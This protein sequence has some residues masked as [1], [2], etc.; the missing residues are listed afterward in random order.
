MQN[1]NLNVLQSLQTNY[2]NYPNF[3][4]F[5]TYSG[6]QLWP[7]E[8]YFTNIYTVQISEDVNKD[9]NENIKN[10]YLGDKI[11]FYDNEQQNKDSI[12]NILDSINEKSILYLNK[13]CYHGIPKYTNNCDKLSEVL[14]CIISKHKSEAIIIIDEM[15]NNTSDHDETLTMEN[16]FSICENRMYKY[17][18]L[19]SYSPHKCK[20][21][22]HIS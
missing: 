5:K 6:L 18:K 17:Y 11:T 8:N 10:E 20:L 16:V 9:L 21:V 4:E 13:T 15:D 2:K 22:I 7:L 1:I 14:S 19:S 12:D 3:I